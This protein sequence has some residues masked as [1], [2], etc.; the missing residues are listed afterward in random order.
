[1]KKNSFT[2]KSKALAL[3]ILINLCAVVCPARAQSEAVVINQKIQQTALDRGVAGLGQAINRLGVIASVLHTGAHPDDEDSGLLAYLA[4]GRQAR[5]A[6]LSLTRGDGGQNLIGPELYESLGVIR[7]DEMLAARR[8]DG[9]S[10][11]FTRAFDFGFSKVREEALSKWDREAVLSDMVRVIRTFRPFVIVSVWTGTPSDGHGHHQAAGLLVQEAYKAA[12]DPA[13]FTELGLRPWKARKLYIRASGRQQG[14]AAQ[15]SE[16]TLSI[17]TGQFDPIL[18]RTYYEVAMQGRSQ[19]RSQDQGALERREPR[20]SRYK[21]VESS[22]GIPKEEKDIFDGMDSTILGIA[23]FAGQKAPQLKQALTEVQR[24]AEQAKKDYNPYST[25]S[26]SGTIAQGLRRLRGIRRELPRMGLGEAE[27]YE[28]DYLLDRKEKDFADAL[29]QANGVIVDCI[30]DDDT[31][32]PGQ[33]FGV[34]VAAYAGEGVKTLQVSLPSREGMSAAQ[35]K[36]ESSVTD[37]RAITQTEFKVTVGE[38][39]EPTA[40]YWLKHPRR[41]A[42]YSPGKGGTGI[43][44][45]APPVLEALVEF[46]IDGERVAV[47]RPAEYR[48]ADKA[49]GEIRHELKIAPIISVTVSPAIIISPTSNRPQERELTVSLVNNSK[50]GVQGSLTLSADGGGQSSQWGIT[51]KQSD[52]DLKREGER[53]SFSHKVTVPANSKGN[54]EIKAVAQV[55]GQ[56]FTEGYQAISYPHTQPRFFYRQAKASAGVFDVKVAPG[57]KVGYIEGAGD[58]FANALKRLGVD[59]TL[60]EAREL[61]SGDLSKYDVIV[62][63]LRVYEVRPDVVSNNRRLLDYVHKGGTLIV[64]YNKGEYAQLN[65]APYSVK[66]KQTPERVTDESAA[67]EILDP[68]HPIFNFPNRI[69]ESDFEGWVQER[70]TYFLSEWDTNFKPMVASRDPGEAPLK[71]GQLI[72]QYGKGHYIYT[73]IA[74]FRQLP[75]GVPGAYRLIANLVSLPKAKLAQPARARSN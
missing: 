50:T 60:I 25:R 36:Q 54:Y 37:G 42:M 30:A 23:D 6:Y 64:Q 2:Q 35:H 4:R 66:M 40:P 24:A 75:E 5:T 48:F 28:V 1:M 65:M 72:A 17:N 20:Y 71:G 70:G 41:G 11:F 58:D 44:P 46:E 10:Q 53:A 33:T 27:M 31:V 62:T 16:A 52:F 45:Q 68:A 22:V 9:A 38:T 7:T 59:V 13:K 55:K 21:L 73:G 69:T 14:Q 49:L 19:H 3:I 29:A 63:G 74:W 18:G 32:T 47:L 51:P 61:A 34:T 26:V 43:E 12:A 57:L 56:Q 39:A 8:L 67:V 15:P